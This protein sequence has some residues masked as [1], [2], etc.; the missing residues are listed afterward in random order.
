[1]GVLELCGVEYSHKNSQILK[2]ISF[3]LAKGEILGLIGPNGAGKSTTIS[4]CATL[5]R[6]S[7]GHVMYYGQSNYDYEGIRKRIG[8]VPQEIALYNNMSAK[9]NLDFFGKLY[10]LKGRELHNKVKEVCDVVKIPLVD[11]KKI[12]E[13]SGGIKRR[14]NIAAALLN[15]PEILIMDEPTVGIDIQSR[16]YI[17]AMVK[18]LKEK[19]TSIIYTTH[20]TD[21]IYEICTRVIGMN[22]GAIVANSSNLQIGSRSE[23]DIISLMTGNL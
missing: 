3:T 20:Y 13:Q 2:G 16:Q 10:G 23:N 21:E 19:E 11:N 12:K 8:L 6:P 18:E 5:L 7:K 4:I 22:N 1:M 14:V 17:L 9:E 15:D